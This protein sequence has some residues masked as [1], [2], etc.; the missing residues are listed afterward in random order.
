MDKLLERMAARHP[1]PSKPGAWYS[2]DADAIFAFLKDE[3]YYV[4]HINK[5][6]IVYRSE[7]T[8]E[9]IGMGVFN[10]ADLMDERIDDGDSTG[11]Q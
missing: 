4:E 3:D 7:E 6:L 8:K 11:Q 1:G 5:N 10:I 2:D 9:I